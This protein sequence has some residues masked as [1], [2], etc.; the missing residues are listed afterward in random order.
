MNLNSENVKK[1]FTNPKSCS[2][3]YIELEDKN[4]DP[5][6]EANTGNIPLNYMI[7]LSIKN[8]NLQQ[9]IM[10]D[11]GQDHDGYHYIYNNNYATLTLDIDINH[12]AE[13]NVPSYFAN[14]MRQ[15]ALYGLKISF[16]KESDGSNGCTEE[17]QNKTTVSD[18]DPYGFLS[19]DYPN[20]TTGKDK[21]KNDAIV[22]THK[23]LTT[24]ENADTKF[25]VCYRNDENN[26][27]LSTNNCSSWNSASAVLVKEEKHYNNSDYK[28]MNGGNDSHSLASFFAVEVAECYWTNSD[29][30][31]SPFISIKSS[32]GGD[33]PL[34]TYVDNF[35]NSDTQGSTL[36]TVIE[37]DNLHRSSANGEASHRVCVQGSGCEDIS[38]QY[39][40]SSWKNYTDNWEFGSV[41]CSKGHIVTCDYNNKKIYTHHQ[42]SD[43]SAYTQHELVI[44]SAEIPTE[45]GIKNGS[46][47]IKKEYIISAYDY[48]GNKVTTEY[49]SF[50][51]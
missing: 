26:E 3:F 33:T 50:K 8:S 48:T 22:L 15:N 7:A 20:Q 35:S 43:V 40:L 21:K 1:L 37:K 24:K 5:I 32:V 27:Q 29:V 49:T 44:Q 46:D 18:I 36:F 4:G 11:G 45:N 28:C 14:L 16:C 10:I 19:Y 39:N 2:D 38:Y 13:H 9:I 23:Y 25:T 30:K 31:T 51:F 12:L 17:S 6:T 34:S 47:R 42:V 41:G